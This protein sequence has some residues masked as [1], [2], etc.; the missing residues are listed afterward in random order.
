[1]R[2]FQIRHP[3]EVNPYLSL[4]TPP[5]DNETKRGGVEGN[6]RWCRVVDSILGGSLDTPSALLWAVGRPDLTLRSDLVEDSDRAGLPVPGVARRSNI[7]LRRI[8]RERSRYRRGP[9]GTR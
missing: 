3:S 8:D 7:R 4:A 5:F 1:M 9:C 6:G 2:E